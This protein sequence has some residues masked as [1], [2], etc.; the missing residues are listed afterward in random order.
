MGLIAPSAKE[1]KLTWVDGR[2]I[3]EWTERARNRDQE[4]GARQ[5]RQ[6]ANPDV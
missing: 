5:S 2:A 6:P 3:P 4:Q 1:I